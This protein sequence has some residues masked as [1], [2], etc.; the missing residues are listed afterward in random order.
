MQNSSGPKYCKQGPLDQCLLN[1]QINKEHI[2]N[3]NFSIKWPPHC[4]LRTSYPSALK[5]YVCLSCW[6]SGVP[7][8]THTAQEH[9]LHCVTFHLK[10]HLQK[11]NTKMQNVGLPLLIH[12]PRNLVRISRNSLKVG[13]HVCWVT[14]RQSVC[15][16]K[17]HLRLCE[18]TSH[19]GLLC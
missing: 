2:L 3:A 13:R 6:A 8:S 15:W 10:R 16:A 19:S 12:I 18:V 4:N 17:T 5:M 7:H 14:R 1:K 11:R 9:G